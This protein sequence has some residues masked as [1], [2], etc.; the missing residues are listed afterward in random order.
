MYILNLHAVFKLNIQLPGFTPDS[1]F[2][3]NFK[4]ARAKKE[5]PA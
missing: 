4:E 1:A 3:N 2:K 5:K